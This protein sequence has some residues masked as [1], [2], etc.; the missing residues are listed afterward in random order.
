MFLK[1]LPGKIKVSNN[2]VV[3]SGN[4]LKDYQLINGKHQTTVSASKLISHLKILS[5]QYPSNLN[6]LVM[7]LTMPKPPH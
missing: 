1:L 2:L 5:L 3:N 6:C 4:F 7:T